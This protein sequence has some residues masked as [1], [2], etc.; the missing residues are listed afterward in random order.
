MH[1]H[2]ILKNITTNDTNPRSDICPKTLMILL[3]FMESEGKNDFSNSKFVMVRGKIDFPGWPGSWLLLG[4]AGMPGR[5]S[6]EAAYSP[7]STGCAM[8]TDWQIQSVTDW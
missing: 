1:E 5:S 7:Y 3:N 4:Y 2:V 8:R 6:Q